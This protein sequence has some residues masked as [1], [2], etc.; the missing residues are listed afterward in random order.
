MFV[1]FHF[2]EILQKQQN[3]QTKKG[4]WGGGGG[5]EKSSMKASLMLALLYSQIPMNSSVIH[6]SIQVF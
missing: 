1:I 3:K 2:G 5:E 4:G 6:F